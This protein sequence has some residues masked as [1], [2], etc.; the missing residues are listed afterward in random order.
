MFTLIDSRVLRICIVIFLFSLCFFAVSGGTED[1][2]IKISDSL[3]LH[4][5]DIITLQADDY[6]YLTSYYAL[7]AC[8]IQKCRYSCLMLTKDNKQDNE[9]NEFIV[10][11]VGNDQIRLRA[12]NTGRY[13]KIANYGGTDT[14]GRKL[15]IGGETLFLRPFII[16]E[17]IRPG[18]DNLFEVKVLN[19][20]KGDNKIA[21]LNV[22][23]SKYLKRFTTTALSSGEILNIITVEAEYPK[24][25]YDFSAFTVTR[26]GISPDY[27]QSV[28]NVTF[29]LKRLTLSNKPSVIIQLEPQENTGN[30]ERSI[31]FND[32]YTTR[33]TNKWTWEKGIEL[34]VGTKIS[35]DLEIPEVGGFGSEVSTEIKTS[36]KETSEYA[37]EEEHA[38][39][40]SHYIPIPP[41][42]RLSAKLIATEATVDVPFTATVYVKSEKTSANYSY[43]INGSY[44][45]T[46][47]LTVKI[48]ITEE[49]LNQTH[50]IKLN[51]TELAE[52]QA[53]VD[54]S[55]KMA[56]QVNL[57][58]PFVV[59]GN[60]TT[61]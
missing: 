24:D 49:P 3:T 27:V 36:T 57:Q 59:A 58:T 1:N 22:Y 37:E 39:S 28:S 2:P 26:T 11:T 53:I 7:F 4:S 51:T 17:G 15:T 20:T 61:K 8:P 50:A 32:Q 42:T 5:G 23:K 40:W 21:L 60:N 54:G 14:W 9:L 31:T 12:K 25:E 18:L 56:Q 43:P 29:D 13:W 35:A 45:G 52:Q 55:T 41:H 6:T 48:N 46:R 16:I 47:F 30:S 44:Q 34:A 10:E 38:V 33:K 19:K